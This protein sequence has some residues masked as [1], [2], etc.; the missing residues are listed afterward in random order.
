[1]MTSYTHES[2]GAVILHTT[3]VHVDA[4]NTLQDSRDQERTIL[5][6]KCVKTAR[7]IIQL[8][9]KIAHVEL[10]F[11][12][13][14]LNESKAHKSLFKRAYRLPRHDRKREPLTMCTCEMCFISEWNVQSLTI[15]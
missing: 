12:C 6:Y 9:R 2:I 13:H 15:R 5:E 14:A 7:T 4:I 10:P 1:M 3:G 8:T 11:R